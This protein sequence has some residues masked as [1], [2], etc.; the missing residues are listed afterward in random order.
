MGRAARAMFLG[1]VCLTAGCGDDPHSQRRIAIRTE[2]IRSN[3]ADYERAE[4][5]RPP[6]LREKDEEL[7]KWWVRDE[8]RF[9]DR[10][11]RIGD[12]AW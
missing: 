1:W 3:V 10:C 6:R 2:R 11:Q 12:Y 7:R 9:R 5:R 4:A 8:E